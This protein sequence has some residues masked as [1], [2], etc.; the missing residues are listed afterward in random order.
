MRNSRR[1]LRLLDRLFNIRPAEWPRLMLLYLMYLVV[2][3]GLTWG[4]TFLEAAFYDQVGVRLL[5]W[6]FV[7]RAILTVPAVAVYTAFADRVANDKLLM[8]IL[9]VSISSIAFGLM[10]LTW[11]QAAIAYSVL[12]L[13]IFIPLD[14]IF[15]THWYTYIND[16]Y[17]TQSAKRVIPVLGT[18]GR[19]AGITAG[20]TMPLLNNLLSAG[21]IVI[22]WASTLI[23]MGIMAWVMPYL[24]KEPQETAKLTELPAAPSRETSQE[25]SYLGNLQEGYRYVFQSPYLRWMALSMLIL[26]LLFAFVQ[27]QIGVILSSEL[28]STEEI[29]NFL[30]RLT[31]ITNLIVFPIQLF[32]L[33]RLIGR[34]GLANTSLVFPLG[35]LTI[36]SILIFFS[37]RLSAALAHFN[38]THFWGA[39]GLPVHSLLYNAV[40]LRV[41]G[42]ARAFIG[43]IVEPVGSFIGGNLLLL[44]PYMPFGGALPV[45]IGVLALAYVASTL[46][47]RRQYTQALLAMLEQEDF[48][49]L[50]STSGS[51][52]TVTDPAM[53]NTLRQRLE[54]SPSHEFTIFMAKLISQVGGQAALPI[55]QEVIEQ[56]Q[57]SRTRAALLDVLIASDRRGEAVRQ[58]YTRFLA[59]PDGRVRRSAIAGLEELFGADNHEFLEP[60]LQMLNDADSEV[61]VQVLLALVDDDNFEKLAPAVEALAQLLKQESPYHRAQGVQILGDLAY[62]KTARSLNSVSKTLFQLTGYLAD[63]ADQVRLQTALALEKISTNKLADQTAELLIQRMNDLVTDP[64]ERVRQAALTVFGRLGREEA[65]PLLLKALTDTSPQIR[66][67]A[68]DTMVEMGKAIESWLQAQLTLPERQLRKMISVILSRIN[69]KEFGGLIQEYIFED[70]LDIY[71]NIGR[72]EALS[73]LQKHESIVVLQHAM[74]EQNRRYLDEIFYLLNALYKQKTVKLISDALQ[75]EEGR[76]RA[77]GVEA[78]ETLTNP[79]TALLIGQLF[80][81]N[82]SPVQLIE[83]GQEVWGFLPSDT[84]QVLKQLVNQEE[85]LW[86]RAIATFA[87]GELGV[88]LSK[89]GHQQT[90]APVPPG[91]KTNG[92]RRGTRLNLFDALLGSDPPAPE[93]NLAPRQ[94][95]PV[96]ASPITPLSR[97]EIDQLLDKAFT[98]SAFEVRLAA[99]DAKRVLAGIELKS[100]L[101]Q[102]EEAIL[103][104]TVE[105]IIFLKE[106]P[107]FQGMTIHQLTVL[108]NV[109]EEQI[110]EED[111]RIFN[112]GDAGGTLYVVVNG[113]VGI[114]QEKRKGSF[115]RL[116]TVEA[117]SYFGETNLFDNSPHT[118]SAIALQDT[119][120]LRLRREP[121]IALARQHPDMS[122]ELINV[123]SQR[124]REANDRVAE[125]TRTRPRELHKLFDKFD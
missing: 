53:L 51:E 27:Y 107:F 119:L 106:V 50:W 83:K 14:E 6:F 86:F 37:G 13:I 71:R 105:K 113:K 60:A 24:L 4:E 110:F 10:L 69:T 57:E 97:A 102:Q 47:I 33:S 81:P 123:L 7:I 74:R 56:T 40:P 19:I 101:S 73:P 62:F 43:G 42:R 65:Y 104:S 45:A 121:L 111:T 59:D 30:A 39:I 22:L 21:E 94:A 16:F 2:L 48:S 31:A 88:A 66:T 12:Y 99:R 68:V 32:G 75:S 52:L 70:L 3:I 91:E 8:I 26:M 122:L 76:T 11:G 90:P 64:V 1:L 120:T 49:F 36:S 55:L 77:N 100:L 17:N 82:L 115:A 5:P 112:Q 15:F 92:K 38:R 117:H 114:E 96:A 34:F 79:Q 18:A 58:I 61:R 23:V 28:G 46:V 87:L 116:A 35:T 89:N 85:N 125:L 9:G 80:E 84:D 20:L 44:L 67:T 103:L 54:S 72:L 108:A 98:D 118:V 25:P 124:L 63:P 41:K 95:E 109:C 29:S 93:A 78:L